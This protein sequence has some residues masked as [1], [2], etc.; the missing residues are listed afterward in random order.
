MIENTNC[1]VT[2][3][4]GESAVFSFPYRFFNASDIQCYLYTPGSESEEVLVRNTDF[5][6]EV[7]SDYSSGAEI[8]LL[9]DPLPVGSKFTILRSV[10]ITQT[11]ALPLLGK[12]PSAALEVQLD[13]LVM[14]LQQL[15]EQLR[16]CI[17]IPYGSSITDLVPGLE[18]TLL[19]AIAAIN[20]EATTAEAR[21]AAITA[22]VAALETQVAAGTAAIDAAKAAVEEMLDG[23]E[24]LDKNTS[25]SFDSV[26]MTDPSDAGQIDDAWAAYEANRAKLAALPRN[27]G[28][29]TLTIHLN[30]LRFG[31]DWGGY[32]IGGF[33][34]GQLFIVGNP[35]SYQQYADSGNNCYSVLEL[36]N[37]LCPVTVS[38]LLVGGALNCA[39]RA[40]SCPCLKI[41]GNTFS[42][43]YT[44]EESDAPYGAAAILTNASAIMATVPGTDDPDAGDNTFGSGVTPYLVYGGSVYYQAPTPQTE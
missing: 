29:H 22:A 38:G 8:T 16:L 14:M 43:P 27:L 7:K 42:G 1:K 26:W 6:V 12:L 20:S 28:G 30:A 3:T 33:Y 21:Y 24:I 41:L 37:C 5:S 17:K 39:V 40:D 2:Y 25:V 15:E 34:N 13:R 31:V 44:Q 19:D 4:V 18:K 32:S 23:A 10:P 35:A 11:L 9:R 36:T